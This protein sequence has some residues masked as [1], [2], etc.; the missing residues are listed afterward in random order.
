M[1]PM[2]AAFQIR[3]GTARLRG[4]PPSASGGPAVALPAGRRPAELRG[5]GG[6][7][8]VRCGAELLADACLVVA[9]VRQ[10]RGIVARV[11]ERAHEPEGG[12]GAQG[13]EPRQRLPALDRVAVSPFPG[14]PGGRR[15][16]ARPQW[17]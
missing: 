9:G 6:D 13:V 10:G 3:V 5:Q 16:R 17:R 11:R 15:P 4:W 7:R 14:G 1:R 12:P 2:T 8:L